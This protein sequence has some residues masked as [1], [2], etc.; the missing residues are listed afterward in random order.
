MIYF[1]IGILILLILSSSF[2]SA[3]ETSLMSLSKIRIRHMAEEG[4]KGAERVKKLIENPSN[5]LAAILVGNNIVNIAASS[6]A[7][8]LALDVSNIYKISSSTGVAL[9]TVIMT[10]IVL[11]FG[12]IIPKTL[13][14]QNCEKISLVVAKPI[15]FI[16]TLLKPL[17]VLS[18]YI[19]NFFIRFFGG[20][21]DKNKP[22]ITEDEL[23]IIVDVSEEEGI[24]EVEEKEM[25]HNVFS[26]GELYIKDVMVQRVDIVALEVSSSIEEVLIT[27]KESGFSR[28]P[29]YEETIDNIVG[30]L[31]AKD[32]LFLKEKNEFNLE[33]YCRNVIYTYEFKKVADLFKEM[34]KLRQHMVVVLDEYGGTVG[35]VTIEDLIEEIVGDITDEY[36]E[37]ETEIYVVKEDEYIVDGSVRIEDINELLGISIES[38]EFDSIGGFIIGV[39]GRFPNVKEEIEFGNYKFVIEE[40]DK[41]RIRKIRIYT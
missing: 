27:I 2:F 25:I 7:T 21:V 41:N 1:K 12:E 16:G 9:S 3:S 38:E 17:I 8:T 24:L 39:L 37:F 34:N 32:L 14:S 11:I 19:S 28:I 6:L 4:I 29:I 18:T 31:N 36:D 23:K 33:N 5:L 26:F 22:F 40:L 13:A 30:I 15:G 20:K 10:I 35:L